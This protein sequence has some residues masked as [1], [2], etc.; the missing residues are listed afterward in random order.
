VLNHTNSLALSG[1]AYLLWI[2]VLPRLGGYHVRQ[3]VDVLDDGAQALRVVKVP[4]SEIAH[5]DATHDEHGAVIQE[6]Q[7]TSSSEK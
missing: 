6:K 4:N 1:L 7:N 5:W 3:V 2:V